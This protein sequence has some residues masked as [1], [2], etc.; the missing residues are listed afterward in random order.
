MKVYVDPACDIYYSSFYIYGLRELYGRNVRFS[1]KYFKIFKHNNHYFP[2]V[3]KQGNQIRK[4]IIDFADGNNIDEKAI[5]WADVYGKVNV[6]DTVVKNKKIVAIGPGFGIRLYSLSSTIF[7][8]FVNFLKSY[9]R[10]PNIRKYLSDYK[11]QYERPKLSDYNKAC[12]KEPYIFFASSLWKKEIDTNNYRANFIKSCQENNRIKFEGGFAPRSKN[13]MKGFESLTMSGRIDMA[14]YMKK[15]KL[16]AVAFNTPAVF[17]CHGW[18]IAE[19]LCMGKAIV[20]TPL[21]RV[22]PGNLIDH[23][24]LLY[25]DGNMSDITEKVNKIILSENLRNELESNAKI[26]FE[27]Y[28]APK[29]VIKRLLQH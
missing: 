9:Q 27:N 29:E 2:F 11:A 12:S 21:S 10:I 25:T 3:V 17:S 6:E 13:D 1:S 23:Q 18:K 15:M 16:S 26:Y 5:G 14:T 8:S 20:S 7:M 28:L 4:V 24:H 22:L 19:F